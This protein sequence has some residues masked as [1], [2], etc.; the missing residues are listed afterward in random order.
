MNRPRLIARTVA[1]L[2]L[3]FAVLPAGAQ[4][5]LSPM[6][7]LVP[8]PAPTNLVLTIDD[9]GSMTSA[10]VPDSVGNNNTNSSAAF[11]SSDYNKLYYSPY[12]DYAIPPNA[13][14]LQASDPS[15]PTSFTA[16]YLDG[17]NP[18]AGTLNLA[19]AYQATLTYTPGATNV[20][21]VVPNPGVGS[22]AAYYYTYN[23]KAGCSPPVAWA[24]PPADNCFTMTLVG[25][26]SGPVVT[27]LRH[28]T[29]GWDETGNFAI[30]YSFYRTRHL[31]IASSAAIA[32][33]DQG[34]ASA[35]VAWQGLTTCNDFT[36]GNTCQGWQTSAPMVDNRLHTFTGTHRTDFYSWLFRVP[37]GNSTPTRLAWWRAGEYFRTSVKT[38]GQNS[39][40][41]ID[42]NNGSTNATELACVNNFQITMTDGQWNTNEERQ[43]NFC[44]NAVCGNVD[45][46]PV[47][48]PD[49]KAYA[50]SASK[51]SS[52]SIY[53]DYNIGGLADIAFYYWSTNL[54]PDLTGTNSA[55]AG[56]GFSGAVMAWYADKGTTNP[57]LPATN[58][59]T[60]DT[61]WPYWNPRNDPA[62]WPHMVNFTI[63]VGL[64]GYLTLPGLNW[65][66]DSFGAMPA[67]GVLNSNGYADLLSLA[68]VCNDTT[69]QVPNP[70][71]CNWP[72]ISPNG[73]ATG[74]G[75]AGG[76][77]GGN[78][79]NVYDL[80]HAAVNS[81]GQAFS[82]ETPTDL[83]TAL[84]T[85]IGRIDGAATGTTAAAA[86]S[87]SLST[88]TA[89]YVASFDPSDWHGTLAAYAIA[90]PASTTPG[91]VAATPTWSTDTAGSIPAFSVRKAF[92]SLASTPLPPSGSA[93]S[94]GNTALQASP[95]WP[96][97]ATSTTA[98]DA[99]GVVN[100]I[101]GDTSN[102]APNG[103]MY[104][105]RNGRQLG[106]IVDSNP[107]Y[108][109]DENYNYQVLETGTNPEAAASYATFVA[110]TKTQSG[111][112]AMVYVGAN[113][114]MLHAFDATAGSS[115][116]GIERFAYVPHSVVPSLPLLAGAN[117]A[118]R[119]F[120]D[121]TPYVGDAFIN[122]AWKTVLVGTTGAGG[123]GVFA[124]DVT[125][126][127]NFGTANVLWDMDATG[128]A[129]PSAAYGN[130]DP[131]LGYTLGQPA[132]VRL[133]DGNWYA[134]FGNGYLS[135]NA[136]PVLYI[137]GLG[138]GDVVKKIY[139]LG[140]AAL[141]CTAANGLGPN[142]LGA[143]TPLDA[144]GNGTT[145]FIYAGDLL[146]NL[147]KFDLRAAGA[148]AASAWA[149]NTNGGQ[150]GPGPLF[151]AMT[152][153][154]P[155]TP[156]A[157][158]G[159]PNLGVA[160]NGVMVYFSTGHL[161]ATGDA[162]DT[163]V[164]SVYAIQ[165]S[166]LAITSRST[167]V[168]QSVSPAADGSGN[169]T[170][171]T[172]PVN[173]LGGT[174]GWVIDL[175]GA[176]ERVLQQPFLVGGV[177]VFVSDIPIGTS[178]KVGC[179]SFLFGVGALSGAGGMDFFSSAGKYYDAITSGVGC[180]AGLTVVVENSTSVLTYAFGPDPG[181]GGPG[182]GSGGSGGGSAGG[183]SLPPP[184]PPC[185]PNVDCS[186]TPNPTSTGRVSWHEMV[187]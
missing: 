152:P 12:I 150:S 182:T 21:T 91:A 3:A 157:I 80:W 132:V 98:G 64:T 104:R 176:G 32:M 1:P 160:P 58:P 165:D 121:A 130:G 170:V 143:P 125:Q 13:A 134:A 111:R 71:W 131:D 78:A 62:T 15:P 99:A 77:G 43:A 50:P 72:T 74:G 124:L 154:T 113:D 118:H 25:T 140:G 41:V 184:Q 34:L 139:A 109:Y 5:A 105:A 95:L 47:T 37:A 122:G 110:T 163:T 148:T 100:F 167:L 146:G 7:A 164:Q 66:Q 81:R 177:L 84:K 120:V 46:T 180:V 181:A 133:N 30:W 23:R 172:S 87:G 52:T 97:L 161:F 86:S 185:P 135:A 149:V 179:K 103:L 65:Y 70:L 142:G 35:R 42:P 117:Y 54:R 187:Q 49:G 119:F 67:G 17:F 106:D 19:S 114:G 141:P 151:T 33:A 112:P 168:V 156:Q 56:T 20:Q 137:V 128:A 55:G 27:T 9:S 186:R 10:F 123:K 44:G 83:V 69:G 2:A 89:L 136:C 4:F 29:A 102:E 101:L 108:A 166:G 68:K 59:A 6:P 88:S 48:L 36:A 79:G 175:P 145:D 178:C 75:G 169:R 162:L 116:V 26:G 63:G 8:A 126:P 147:W 173:L 174:N 14:G 138:T 96:L 40:Y 183:T 39:P 22:N 107:V 92:T 24:A 94:A 158:V 57:L 73:A 45:S 153:G 18:A 11:T 82:A 171:G 90:G 144:D 127:Q 93:F 115:T 38:N 51:A 76:A 60:V 85:I 16:A 129:G 53:S 61:N 31:A 28:P 159:A 155:A